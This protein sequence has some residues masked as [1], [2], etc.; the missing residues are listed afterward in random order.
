MPISRLQPLFWAQKGYFVDR[1]IDGDLPAREVPAFPAVYRAMDRHA[2]V[3]PTVDGPPSQGWD[4]RGILREDLSFRTSA[5]EI[6]V[7][8]ADIVTNAATRAMNGRLQL[9]GWRRLGRLLVRR[10]EATIQIWTTGAAED[11]YRPPFAGTFLAMEQSA[12][13]ML[14]VPPGYTE[15]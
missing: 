13:P 2:T 10:T 15:D 12:R 6:A 11:F 9:A 7:Q 14:K 8:L 3:I 5:D 4:L 1:Y